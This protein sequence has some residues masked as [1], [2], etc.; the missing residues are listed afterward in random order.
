LDG[1]RIIPGDP[2]RYA[3]RRDARMRLENCRGGTEEATLAE[4][5]QEWR[6]HH[7]PLRVEELR[8]I[9]AEMREDAAP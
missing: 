9:L 4:I 8:A 3:M 2:Y 6:E 7:V 1:P 5:A